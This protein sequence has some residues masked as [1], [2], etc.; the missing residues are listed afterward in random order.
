[1]APVSMQCQR[2]ISLIACSLLSCVQR[3]AVGDLAGLQRLLQCGE[4]WSSLRASLLV[5]NA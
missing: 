5:R 4:L 1:M 2:G 3:F